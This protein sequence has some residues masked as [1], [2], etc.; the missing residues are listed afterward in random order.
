MLFDTFARL[1]RGASIVL[2]SSLATRPQQGWSFMPDISTATADTFE[3]FIPARL[4]R[5]P[6]C[7]FHWM[8]V[9]GLGITWVLDGLEVTLMGAISAVLERP[10]VMH[11]SAAQIGFIS[12]CYLTG[13]VLGSLVFGHLTDRFGRRRFFFWSLSI[14]LAGVGLTALS[15]NLVSFA[16]FRFL[17][18]AGIGGEYSAVN[19]AI[20]ELI[21]ARLRGRV[22]LIVNGSFW[23]GA[24][25]GAASTVIILNPRIFPYYLGWR[26][27]FG[28]GAMIGLGIL[29]LRRFI[30]ESPRWMLTHGYRDEAE[31][32]VAEIERTVAEETGAPLPDPP[33]DHVLKIHPRRHFGLRAVLVPM[34]TTYRSRSILGLTLMVA[35]AFTYN[36][37][38]FTYALVLHHFYGVPA[39]GTGLYL[40]P[41]ALGNFLG[42]VVLGH[43]FDT[44]GRC[45][46]ISATFAISAA[47]MVAIGWLFAHGALSTFSQTALW[48]V[49][50]FFASPAA[51]SAY[52]T[53]S[54]IF[55]LEMRALAIAVFYSAGTAAGGIVAPWFFGRLIDT[56]SRTALMYGY[57]VAAA[58]M[59]AAAAV[60]LLLGVAAEGQSLES[61]AP[62]LSSAP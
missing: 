27:G 36:A 4:D 57:L 52:L 62:P 59:F 3:T 45:R 47:L 21:P 2:N 46:M 30:P 8:L 11:F 29:F 24:A 13:A 19:S 10:D 41:F 9:I 32:V 35:Q 55:P 18:G 61:I 51:S 53:V 1:A 26:F 5:L 39:D 58:L 56:G 38:L 43:F 40:L 34:V 6:W 33:R 42:P 50:F 20:D 44:I 22:D 12:S 37:I 14:Y 7:R 28:I 31:N 54:E 16:L 23:L 60:E 48:T 17:T 49:M 15:T 25:A